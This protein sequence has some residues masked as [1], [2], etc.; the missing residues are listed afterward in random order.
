MDS[1]MQRGADICKALA[2]VV[3]VVG[4]G[5]HSV[6]IEPLFR[7]FLLTAYHLCHGPMT[8]ST[9]QANLTSTD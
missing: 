7:L 4:V 5:E 6:S 3:D 1:E 8:I 9:T 2:L